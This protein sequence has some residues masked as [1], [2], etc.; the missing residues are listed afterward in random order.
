LQALCSPR[1][2][3]LAE[4]LGIAPLNFRQASRPR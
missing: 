1:V 4:D 3:Q 2:R